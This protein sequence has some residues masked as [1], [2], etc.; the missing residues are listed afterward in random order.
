MIYMNKDESVEIKKA[1]EEDLSSITEAHIKVFNDYFLTS[2]G[3]S[4]VNKYYK[5]YLSS[6][7]TVFYIATKDKSIVGFVLGTLD[8]DDTMSRFYRKNF[9]SIL[10]KI[11]K[12]LLKG[13]KNM[14]RGVNERLSVIKDVIFAFQ[15]KEAKDTKTV[16]KVRLMSIGILPEYRGTNVASDLVKM[17]DKEL[18]TRGKKSYCLAFKK[19]N[20]RAKAFYTKMGFKN[21]YFKKNLEVMKKDII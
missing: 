11:I 8:L 2:L 20:Y 1:T 9:N 5:E 4:M 6:N 7:N 19:D 16:L 12:E 17:F 21:Y 15:K 18:L 3:S 10:K 13:N 14:A